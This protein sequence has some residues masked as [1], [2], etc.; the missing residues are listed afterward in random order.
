MRQRVLLIVL[1]VGNLALAIGWIVSS[2]RGNARLQEVL[3][4]SGNI[5]S[6][7]KTNV[8]VRRQFFTWQQIESDDYPNYVANLREIGC[9]E[10]TVRD[11]IVA[12]VNA[13]YARK[14]ATEVVTS[15]QQW[16]RTEP[17]TNLTLAA[18]A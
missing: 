18:A 9:P 1:L 13:V 11:I 14:R 4:S 2:H 15:E 16:W 10:Q 12:D 8:V 6:Q 17:D 5:P 7:S 3:T